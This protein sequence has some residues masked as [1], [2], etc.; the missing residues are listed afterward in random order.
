MFLKKFKL[1]ISSILGKK[2]KQILIKLK[3]NLQL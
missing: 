2:N 3:M 1:V